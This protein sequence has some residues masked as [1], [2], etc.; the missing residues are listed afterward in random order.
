M[1]GGQ[2]RGG[3]YTA[4]MGGCEVDLR[5]ATIEGEA[6][7]DAFA[8]WGGIEI[9]VPKTFTVDSRVTALLG[10][11]SDRTDHSEADPDQRLIVRGM[12]LMGGVDVKN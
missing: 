11:F 4:V 1:T 12:A 6:T 9:K 5:Q 8:F 3:D 10:G 7:I 2:F